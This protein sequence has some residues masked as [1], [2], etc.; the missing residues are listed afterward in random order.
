MGQCNSFCIFRMFFFIFFFPSYLQ[1]LTQQWPC[2]TCGQHLQP[3]LAQLAVQCYC[4]PDV[5]PVPMDFP[6]SPGPLVPQEG[7]G[8]DQACASPKPKSWMGSWKPSTMTGG[9]DK[10]ALGLPGAGLVARSGT[11]G[12]CVQVWTETVLQG[13]PL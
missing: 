10:A 12:I 5:P 4:Q 9:G 13:Q 6:R 11:L 8:S 3:S 7:G 2:Y 1:D